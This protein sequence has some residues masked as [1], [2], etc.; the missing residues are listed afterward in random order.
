MQ[1]DSKEEAGAREVEKGRSRR[2]I[3]KECMESASSALFKPL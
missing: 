2:H 3:V 1:D